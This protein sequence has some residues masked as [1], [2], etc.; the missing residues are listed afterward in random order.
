M[1]IAWIF[2]VYFICSICLDICG[3]LLHAEKIISRKVQI[4]HTHT[5]GW[6]EMEEY[7]KGAR[8]ST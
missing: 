1:N 8:C 4:T 7:I 2:L 3:V 5:E 6:R